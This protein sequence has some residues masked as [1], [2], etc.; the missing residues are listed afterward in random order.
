VENVTVD[1]QGEG[2]LTERPLYS[3]ANGG[4]PP[5]Y[6]LFQI[7]KT[8]F[9]LLV[10]SF[11]AS[12]AA[13]LFSGLAAHK[14]Q[15]GAR[16]AKILPSSADAIPDAVSVLQSGVVIRVPH[17]DEMTPVQGEDWLFLSW[18]KL[19]KTVTPDERIVLSAKYDPASKVRPGFSVALRGG[20]DGTRPV[21]YWQNEEG[22]GKWFTFAPIQFQSKEWYLLA[23]SF[24]S[25]TLGM[26]IGSANSPKSVLSLGG[27]DVG[28]EVLPKTSSELIVGSF[29]NGRFRGK[30]GPFGVVK[31]RQLSKVLS[32]IIKGTALK[33][34]AMPESPEGGRVIFWTDG[35]KDFGPNNLQVST[36]YPGGREPSGE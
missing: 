15:L 25:G 29:A 23:L 35:T 28:E 3:S 4:S 19:K 10:A 20:I 6:Y 1:A 12:F 14:F 36:V 22:D 17:I 7:P 33:P 30:I 32:N 21:V 8:A 9:I 2:T 26:H 18:I 5:L 31:G 24:R 13:V 11:V 16:F 34:G 27:Y